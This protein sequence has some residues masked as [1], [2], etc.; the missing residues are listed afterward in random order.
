MKTNKQKT[1]W[2]LDTLLFAGF[3]ITFALDWTGLPMHQWMGTFGGLLAT[4]HLIRH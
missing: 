1:N 4:Y 2:I 3:L